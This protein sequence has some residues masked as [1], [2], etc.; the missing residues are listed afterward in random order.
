MILVCFAIF[1]VVYVKHDQIWGCP[2]RNKNQSA[3]P[4]DFADFAEKYRFCGFCGKVLILR[5]LRN[6]AVFS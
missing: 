1:D 4:A 5:I 3:D 6:C 2:E